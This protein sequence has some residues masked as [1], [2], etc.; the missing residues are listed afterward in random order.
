MAVY[1]EFNEFSIFQLEQSTAGN[2]YNF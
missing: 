1:D 2:D